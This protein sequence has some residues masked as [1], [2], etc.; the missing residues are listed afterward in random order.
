MDEALKN[1]ISGYKKFRQNYLSS[2]FEAN[3]QELSKG[4]NPKVMIISCSDSRVN[5][6]VL[7]HAGLGE[8]FSVSNVA[9]LVPPYKEGKETHHSTSAAIEFAVNSL[10]VEHIIIMGH[11]SCGG[12]QSLM[13]GVHKEHED[14]YS[15]IEPWMEIAHDAKEKVLSEHP[16]ADKDE[17]EHLCE[18]EALL[19]SLNNLNGFP[20]VKKGK[21]KG[22]LKTHAWYYD[23]S[24]GDIS[25]WDDDMQKF[26]F[27]LE[28]EQNRNLA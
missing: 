18:K 2:K 23:I 3:R 9:N 25:F 16:N 22:T 13:S 7:T 8:I 10:K 28:S 17:K 5:P 11:S 27:L 4:Q 19:I 14:T 15:F 20:W 6:A 24:A 1:L 26:T 12:I 21:A